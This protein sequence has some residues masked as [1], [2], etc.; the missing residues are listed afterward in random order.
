M[1]IEIGFLVTPWRPRL[2]VA[3]IPVVLTLGGCGSGSGAT[4]A[5]NPVTTTPDATN[6]TGPPPQTE[7]VQR[8]KL[9]VWDRLV[10]TNR[11]G[12]CHEPDQAP[13]F[14][15]A[16]D[17]NL[18]YSEANTVV[19]LTDP[20]S[21]RMV[22]KVRGGHH[23][24]LASDSACGDIVQQ[25]IEAWA[26]DS[27]GGGG[28][29]IQLVAPTI[30]DPGASKN[31]PSDPGLFANTVHPLLVAHCA[32]CHVEASVT[33]Q[34]P[35]FAESDAAVAYEGAKSKMDIDT[36]ANSRFVLRLG[37][38]FHHCWDDCDAN[39][40]EMQAAIADLASGIAPTQV[41]PSLVVSKALNLGDGIISS[42][43]GRHE[44]NLIALYEFKAG[45]GNMAFDTS[46][47]DPAVNL[48]FSGTV[49]WVGGWGIQIVD[50]K[51]QGSTTA[52]KKLH[53]LITATGEYS[54]EAW[55][56]P[57]NVTQ[58][59]PARI[60]SYSGGENTRNF[61]IGQ[62]LYSYDFLNRTIGADQ[63]GSPELSTADGDRDLQATLQHVVAVFD[64]VNGRRIYVNGQFTD[65]LDPLPG[66]V[67]TDWND[68]FALAVGS[69]VDQTNKWAG[70]VRLLAI[71]NRALTPTQIQQNHAAGVGEKFFLL[72]NISDHV[73]IPDAY[74]VFEVSQFDSFSYL[75]IEP[76]LIILDDA[77]LPGQIPI[78][79]MRIGINGREAVAGQAYSNLDV[80]TNDADYAVEGRQFLSSLGTTIALEKGAAADEFFLSFEVLGDAVNVIVEADPLP[81]PPPADVARDP[82]IGL[83]TFDE[84]NATMSFMTGIPGTQPDVA[85]T[86]DTIRQG[87]PSAVS[88]QGFLSSQQMGVTQLAIEYCSAL[89]EDTNLRASYFPGFDFGQAAGAAFDTVGRSQVVT[90]LL[91]AMVGNN[92]DTQPDRV[93]LAGEINSLIDR[94][95]SCGSGCRSDRTET[96]VKAVCASVLG[97]ATML[98][99]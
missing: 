21:S 92:L 93:A 36:P 90:P 37:S 6:Y 51:A 66:D 47:V 59:G 88:I 8:F 74:I 13:R 46:G 34:P 48:T 10:P 11:C 67:L 15:R 70:T 42:S 45:A 18:A 80:T 94:L 38:E 54:I 57:A 64:P 72:F 86:F 81:P 22:V 76:F 29:V 53:D 40:A 2:L 96:V 79:G 95:T 16:D 71:H 65:D 4:T 9:N 87:L 69:E 97:G 56:A 23:C 5:A 44:A 35:F 19:D 43:G 75:F 58:E 73:D 82:A 24:W 39:A 1:T 91:D 31:F 28:K 17:I 61:M 89:V 85:S 14:V 3:L 12:T 32:N 27:V 33:A 7:D 99:Q 25:F 26:G 77:L 55:V 60:V 30:K 98:L 63:N 68:T 41:D 20:A 78:R 49:N 84:I 62:T 50:G 52:S 83:R